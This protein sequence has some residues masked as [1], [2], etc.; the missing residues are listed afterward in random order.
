[1]GWEIAIAVVTIAATIWVTLYAAR[2]REVLLYLLKS[3]RAVSDTDGADLRAAARGLRN[4]KIL[5]IRLRGRGRRD[6]PADAFEAGEPITMRVGGPII[7]LIGNPVSWPVGRSG[8]V[9]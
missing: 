7:Q 5:E 3:G 1:M 4:P 6:I 2:P 8:L 9:R